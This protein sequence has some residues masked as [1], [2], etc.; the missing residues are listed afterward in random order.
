MMSF[1]RR[2]KT[3]FAAVVVLLCILAPQL[4]GQHEKDPHRPP[5]TSAPCQKIESFLRAHFCGASA[6]GNGPQNGCDTRYSK[7]LL[8]GVN[9]I[10]A[11]DCETSPTDGRPKCRQRSQPPPAVRSLLL[12]E[13]R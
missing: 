11:F 1:L 3:V 7:Q 2:E 10:A 5:C 13:M 4:K 9:V 12:R 6:F 8:T